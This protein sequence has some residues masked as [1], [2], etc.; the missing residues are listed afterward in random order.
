MEGDDGK[1]NEDEYPTFRRDVSWLG[2]SYQGPST[3]SK[4]SGDGIPAAL[5]LVSTSPTSGKK[6]TRLPRCWTTVDGTLAAVAGPVLARRAGSEERR[7]DRP[8]ASNPPRSSVGSK[9]DSMEGLG[10]GESGSTSKDVVWNGL[11]A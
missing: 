1:G 5:V 9:A 8:G 2:P 10:T 4:R 3:K 7:R 6:E 11:K